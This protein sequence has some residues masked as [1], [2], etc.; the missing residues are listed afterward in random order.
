MVSAY[1]AMFTWRQNKELSLEIGL[2]YFPSIYDN[3]TKL[4]SSA[5]NNTGTIR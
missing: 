1:Q 5:P 4:K 2:F 3:L